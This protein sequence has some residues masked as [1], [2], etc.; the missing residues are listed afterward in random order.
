[1]SLVMLGLGTALPPTRID[2]DEAVR[3]AQAVCSRTPEQAELLPLLYRLTGI[4]TRHMVLPPDI[5]RDVLDGTNG[6]G[7]A[8]VPSGGAGPTTAQRMAHYAELA[9]PLAAE[10]AG[11]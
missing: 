3:F 11:A 1:M 6:S 9:P 5:V 7:S 10:A 2:Q 4:D 8:F